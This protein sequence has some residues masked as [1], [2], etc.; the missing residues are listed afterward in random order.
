MAVQPVRLEAAVHHVVGPAVAGADPAEDVGRPAAIPEAHADLRH[1]PAVTL[2]GRD[3]PVEEGVRTLDQ[4][5]GN[6]AP[7]LVVEGPDAL[8]TVGENGKG[9]VVHRKF[10][11]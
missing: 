6:E 9:D 11:G 8:V 2:P 5:L 7:A 4:F 1:D 3:D 10:R